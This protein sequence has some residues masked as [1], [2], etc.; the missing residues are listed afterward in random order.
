VRFALVAA[1]L[2]ACGNNPAGDSDGG[3]DDGGG[4][5]DAGVDVMIDADPTVR[6]TVTVKIVDKNGVALSGMYV[7]FIDTDATVTERMTDA[8]GNAQADVYPNA[9]VTAIR[10]RGM[11]YAIV[12][13]Q[14]LNPGDSITLVSAASN[15]TSSEDPFSQRVV[16]MPG[17]DIAASPN[18]ASKAGTAGTFTTIAPHGLAVGD[19]VLVSNVAQPAYNGG[20]VVASVPSATTFTVTMPAGNLP[21]SGTTAVGATAMKAVRFTVNYAANAG[22]GAYEVHTSCGTTN[23]GTS[24]TP[25]LTLPLTCMTSPMDIVVLAKTATTYTWAQQA[26]VTVTHGGSTTISGGWNARVPLAATYSN[27]SPA[28][29][30]LTLARF[31]PYLRGIAETEASAM[32]NGTT[33]IMLDASTP[34]RSLLSTQITCP[35]TV[36]GCLSTPMGSAAQR[37]TQSVDGTAATYA[38]DIGASLLPWIKA[39]YVPATTMFEITTMGSVPFDIFEAN[40]RYVRG[41][42][43]IYTWRVFGPVAQTFQFPTLPATAPGNPTVLPTDVMSSY[44]AFIGESDAVSG[45]RDAIK[46]PFAALGACEASANAA[47][48][49]YGGANNRIS[50]WN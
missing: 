34:A 20:W 7:V 46:N 9:S 17:A 10:N 35:S 11:S 6:G 28:G 12:T 18:G 16:P 5:G 38:L 33:M 3:G 30:G 31:S 13:V 1:L 48:T 47:L 43:T 24:L 41:G 26:N 2:A 40:L 44:Q 27:P 4:D 37:I 39:N 21:N 22:T 32:A 42:S 36:S 29:V 45:Y 49:P 8:A 15:V 50:Q 14:A 25:T 19:G 23:V